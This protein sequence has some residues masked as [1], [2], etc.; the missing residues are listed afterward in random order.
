VGEDISIAELAELIREVVGYRGELRFDR[1]KPD[2][3]PRKLLDVSRL[4]SLGWQAG[5]PLREGIE[6]TY[7]W[8]LEQTVKRK[9]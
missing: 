4:Q 6:Q 2:G 3:T 9:D 8:Y 7:R 5:I 1:S